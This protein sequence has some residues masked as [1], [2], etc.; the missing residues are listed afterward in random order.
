M[1]AWKD[2]HGIPVGCFGCEHLCKVPGIVIGDG[3]I[4][5]NHMCYHPLGKLRR[6]TIW[7]VGF[8]TPT[9]CP[10]RKSTK[11]KRKR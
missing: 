5:R 2:K 6:F 9:W 4:G 1:G 8:E 10:L 7:N 3:K 11:A